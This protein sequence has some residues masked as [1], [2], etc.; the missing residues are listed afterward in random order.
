M[1][2][3]VRVVACLAVLL[4]GAGAV[5][6]EVFYLKDGTRIAGVILGFDEGSFHV[7]TN[8]GPDVMRKVQRVFKDSIVY[9]LDHRQEALDYAM[10]YSRNAKPELIDRFVGMYVNDYTVDMG[11]KGKEGLQFLRDSALSHGFIKNQH[12]VNFV[13]K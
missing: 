10:K 7:R 3:P 8:L 1:K 13:P 6:A 4:L 5:R 9:A 2:I 11:K 12:P